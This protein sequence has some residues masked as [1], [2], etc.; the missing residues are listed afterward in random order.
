[1]FYKA[2]GPAPG[3]EQCGRA[4]LADV[5]IVRKTADRQHIY[6]TGKG[7]FTQVAGG[8]LWII[9]ANIFS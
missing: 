1:M 5:S 2:A 4:A 9:K 8:G 3:A 6:F 7:G